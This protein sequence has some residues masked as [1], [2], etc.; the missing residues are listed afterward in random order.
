LENS[1]ITFEMSDTKTGTPFILGAPCS[2]ALR[3]KKYN[4]VVL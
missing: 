2:L 3:I 4:Q 1:E